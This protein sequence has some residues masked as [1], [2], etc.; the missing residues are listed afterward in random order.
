MANILSLPVELR[1]LIFEIL[2]DLDDAVCLAKTCTVFRNLYCLHKPQLL[3]SIIR[4]SDHH[5][6][7]AALCRLHDLMHGTECDTT[8]K[9]PIEQLPIPRW[10]FRDYSSLTFDVQ[11]QALEGKQAERHLQRIL[12]W[13]QQAT[14]IRNFYLNNIDM[15]CSTLAF[16]DFQSIPVEQ[17]QKYGLALHFDQRVQLTG[18]FYS[19][20]RSNLSDDMVSKPRLYR[21][22]MGRFLDTKAAQLAKFCEPTTSEQLFRNVR[23]RWS[24]NPNRTLEESLEVLEAFDIVSNFMLLHILKDP[25]TILRWADTFNDEEE[26]A[27]NF[28][29]DPNDTILINWMYVM[30]RLQSYLTPFDILSLASE[31]GEISQDTLRYFAMLLEQPH[32]EPPGMGDVENDVFRKLKDEFQVDSHC[33]ILYRRHNW[34]HNLRSKMF[35]ED[36]CVAKIASSIARSKKTKYHWWQL[37]IPGEG[38]KEERYGVWSLYLKKI[39][40]LSENLIDETEW[41][42]IPS[43]GLCYLSSESVER[44]IHNQESN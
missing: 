21:A 19:A 4:N 20:P 41:Y 40:T 29:P 17:R 15:Y 30:K 23:E 14:W 39:R 32:G 33:W 24:Y 38:T 27:Q 44:E 37:L 7:D 35:R 8:L 36:L 26:M 31:K 42:T 18:T 5:K 43:E 1:L 13:W 12:R 25:D 2:H 16:V 34:I 6:Y 22:A 3:W 11:Q 28:T 10:M 9:P